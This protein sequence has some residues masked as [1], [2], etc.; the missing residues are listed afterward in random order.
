MRRQCL[1]DESIHIVEK[2]AM[3]SNNDTVRVSCFIDGFNLYHAI[4][5]MKANYLKWLNL[6]SLMEVFIEKGRHEIVSI[7]YFS[8]YANW[9]PSRVARHR[10][11]IAALK[12]VG[13]DPVMGT[14][15]P[16]Q[17]YCRDCKKKWTAHEEKQTD[18]NI[19]V[20]MVR[21]AFHDVFDEAFLVSGDS[22]LVPPI[23]LMRELFP[24]KRIKVICPP[25]RYFGK[26]LFRASTGHGKIKR[27]HLE[28]CLFQETIIGDHGNVI[29]TRPARY[30]PPIS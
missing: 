15:K 1:R 27:V 12:S 19:A 24:S 20:E 10:E 18:V 25:D 5:A 8:A 16:K 9:V 4:D 3:N 22:D 29:A 30:K 7:Q 6:N 11:Y 17:K 14:F 26:E 2:R 21:G 23:K 13:V 28:E